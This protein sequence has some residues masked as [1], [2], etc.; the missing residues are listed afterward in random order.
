MEAAGGT[1]T[2]GRL[3][4]LVTH[5]EAGRRLVEAVCGDDAARARACEA[6]GRLRFAN[7]EVLRAINRE[8]WNVSACDVT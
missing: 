5:R 1:V 6:V 7:E 3:G 8:T 2:P 4:R